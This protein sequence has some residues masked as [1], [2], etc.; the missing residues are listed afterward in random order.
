MKSMQVRPS[1]QIIATAFFTVLAVMGFQSMILMFQESARP[2]KETRLRSIRGEVK[3][4]QE[5]L[6]SNQEGICELNFGEIENVKI[7]KQTKKTVVVQVR[8]DG[9]DNQLVFV[10]K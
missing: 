6:S 2:D 10:N 9:Q 4:C 7:Y 8:A 5:L 3:R 1:L